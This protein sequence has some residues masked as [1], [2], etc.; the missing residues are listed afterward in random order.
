[1]TGP[2]SGPPPPSALGPGS[3]GQPLTVVP[4]AGWLSL[5]MQA[6]TTVGVPTVFAGV[7]LWFVLTRVGDT[8][9]NISEEE[10]NRTRMLAAMQD[11]VIAALER[12]TREFVTVM[13]KNIATNKATGE[14][15]DRLLIQRAIQR[16][17]LQR[18]EHE[19]LE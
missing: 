8:L 18:G 9:K 12:Q 7:L 14:A 19:P 2:G 17:E 13:E 6:V 4:G 16:G 5:A 15:V 1:M 3:P 11:T 10:E